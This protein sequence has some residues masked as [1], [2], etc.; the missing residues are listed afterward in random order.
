VT[1]HEDGSI[2][3]EEFAHH[4]YAVFRLADPSD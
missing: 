2:T 1:A 4:K 3:D